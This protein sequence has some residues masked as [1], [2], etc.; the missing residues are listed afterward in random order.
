MSEIQGSFNW[1]WCLRVLLSSLVRVGSLTS[2]NRQDVKRWRRFAARSIST[3][4]Q[5]NGDILYV[6]TR[7]Y[8][9]RRH[10]RLCS[11]ENSLRRTDCIETFKRLPRLCCLLL[12]TPAQHSLSEVHVMFCECYFLSIFYGRLMLRPRLMEVR[13]TFTRGGPWVW[14]EKILLQ[15]FPGPP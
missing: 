14:I 9:I 7:S 12:W 11:T 3:T 2:V 8:L 6:I 4:L 13:K 1:L 15:L 5:H 10:H